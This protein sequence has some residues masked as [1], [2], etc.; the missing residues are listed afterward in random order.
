MLYIR[1]ATMQDIDLLIRLRMD[2]LREDHGAL[3]PDQEDAIK[4]QLTDYFPKHLQDGTFIGVLAEI[5]G[6]VVSVAYL[7]ISEKPA[8]PAFITGV[9]GTLLN[10]L[11]FPAYRKQGIATKVVRRIME[12]AKQAGVSSIELSATASGRPL[13]EKLGFHPSKY[14]AMRVG[15]V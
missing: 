13:Y 4:R 6:A 15:L 1:K 10:V 12:E 9:T 8:N 5:D 2:Y 3:Q 7:A 11:T 14:T